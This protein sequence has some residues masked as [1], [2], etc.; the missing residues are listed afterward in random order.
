MVA[1]GTDA[2]ERPA[3]LRS[4]TR[5]KLPDCC[6]LLAAQDVRATTVLPFDDRLRVAAREAGHRT[7][8]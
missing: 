8:P 1:V 4:A 7:E 5:L 3:H 6:V 2:P